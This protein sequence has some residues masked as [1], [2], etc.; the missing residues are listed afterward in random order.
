[1]KIGKKRPAD[2]GVAGTL[3]THTS[4]ANETYFVNQYVSVREIASDTQD[5]GWKSL[6]TSGS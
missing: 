4:V 6:I 1:M 3:I 5:V 2:T